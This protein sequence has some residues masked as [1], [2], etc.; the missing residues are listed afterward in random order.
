MCLCSNA[1][2]CLPEGSWS[3]P[4]AVG[5]SKLGFNSRELSCCA[6]AASA[7]S[8]HRLSLELVQSK[9]LFL[10]LISRMAHVHECQMYFLGR[11][12]VN[13]AIVNKASGIL[14]C[15]NFCMLSVQGCIPFFITFYSLFYLGS[16]HNFVLFLL[17]HLYVGTWQCAAFCAACILKFQVVNY[18]NYKSGTDEWQNQLYNQMNAWLSFL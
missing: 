4:F 11:Y 3:S 2:V 7:P 17:D 1:L 13:R 15:L 5:Q 6:P 14:F 8:T 10:S 12:S 18:L 16:D 9:T